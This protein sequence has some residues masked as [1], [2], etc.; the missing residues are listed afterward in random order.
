MCRHKAVFSSAPIANR[1]DSSFF[2]VF[3][4]FSLRVARIEAMARSGTTKDKCVTPHQLSFWPLRLP[5]QGGAAGGE[6][7]KLALGPEH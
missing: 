7:T 2:C 6:R 4:S 5:T 3:Q 1:R